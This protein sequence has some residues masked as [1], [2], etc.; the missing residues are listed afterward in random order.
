M[1]HKRKSNPKRRGRRAGSGE[2]LGTLLVILA[3]PAALIGGITLWNRRKAKA[4][5]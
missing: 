2:A 5:T 3:V 1:T 4:I